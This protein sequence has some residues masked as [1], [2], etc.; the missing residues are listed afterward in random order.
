[1]GHLGL[2]CLDNA[3]RVPLRGLNKQTT[4]NVRPKWYMGLVITPMLA[5]REK[6][7]VKNRKY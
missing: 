1:M 6:K 3:R 2:K 5:Y 7:K 4:P